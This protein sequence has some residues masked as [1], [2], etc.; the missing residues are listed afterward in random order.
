MNFKLRHPAGEIIMK[1]SGSPYAMGDAERDLATSIAA[2]GI[3][4]NCQTKALPIK[5]DGDLTN[6]VKQFSEWVRDSLSPPNGSAIPYL[7]LIWIEW[8]SCSFETL[9]EGEFDP[10]AFRLQRSG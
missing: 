2:Y 8:F 7:K 3:P 4:S 5:P 9:K 1:T 6:G 10:S